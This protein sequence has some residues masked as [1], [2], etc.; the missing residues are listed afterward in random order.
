MS[1][2]VT[3]ECADPFPQ[4]D[5]VTFEISPH[6]RHVV[7]G[8]GY[9]HLAPTAGI[10]VDAFQV[11]PEGVAPAGVV[12]GDGGGYLRHRVPR[13]DDAQGRQERRSR[14]PQQ[15]VGVSPLV[16]VDIE[17]VSARVS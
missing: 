3:A 4:G 15:L 6:G 5:T 1:E 17:A 7:D 14:V 12:P 9:H 10:L 8:I 11:A 16:G 2:V 13:V